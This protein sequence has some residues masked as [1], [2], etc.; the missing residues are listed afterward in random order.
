MP[1]QNALIKTFTYNI[2]WAFCNSTQLSK[3][4]FDYYLLYKQIRHNITV[5]NNNIIISMI[6]SWIFLSPVATRNI[7]FSLGKESL[8]GTT[9]WVQF[10]AF[11]MMSASSLIF[12]KSSNL[13]SF[14]RHV[15]KLTLSSSKTTKMILLYAEIPLVMEI[16]YI[17]EPATTLL[18]LK[19]GHLNCYIHNTNILIPGWK[20]VDFAKPHT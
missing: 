1:L 12:V 18:M 11:F 9:T 20:N 17:M 16:W 15:S 13:L 3:I 6:I 8:R 19:N 10:V 5:S 7:F 14:E 4:F 2:L